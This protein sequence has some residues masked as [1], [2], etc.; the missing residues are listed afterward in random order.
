MIRWVKSAAPAV[1]PVRWLVACWVASTLS[2]RL[3]TSLVVAAAWGRVVGITLN[4]AVVP[5]GFTAA[6][7][8]DATPAVLAMADCMLLTSE[9]FAELDCLGSRTTTVSGPLAPAP[10]PWDIRS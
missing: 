4:T 5:A 6:G 7:V 3:V 1:V 9:L 2:R 10:K 8:T